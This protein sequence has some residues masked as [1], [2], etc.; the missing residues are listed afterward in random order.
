VPLQVGPVSQAH[1]AA[2]YVALVRD[3]QLQL[4]ND[5]ATWWIE[6][7]GYLETSGYAGVSPEWDADELGIDEEEDQWP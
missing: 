6:R 5:F 1:A 4:A 3:Q 7:T 2:L